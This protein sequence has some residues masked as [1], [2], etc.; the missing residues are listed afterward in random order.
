MDPSVI[1]AGLAA[2]VSLLSLWAG[3]RREKKAL[4]IDDRKQWT[5]EFK[6]LYDLLKVEL[7]QVRQE[8]DETRAE[9]AE[10]RAEITAL[11]VE[12]HEWQAGARVPL[13]YKLVPREE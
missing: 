10:A 2:L 13:G 5:D 12:L 7:D 6:T 11:R 1:A 4:S 3:S 9:L 8:L